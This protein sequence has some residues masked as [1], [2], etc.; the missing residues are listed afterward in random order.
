MNLGELLLKELDDMLDNRK[1]A[2]ANG[3]M[4]DYAE[5]QHNVGVIS[6][7]AATRERLKDLLK[8]EEEN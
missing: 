5:Y 4:K 3:R 6:G 1:E 7:L 8:Y 2:L